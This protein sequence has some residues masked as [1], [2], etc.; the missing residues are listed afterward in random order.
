MNIIKKNSILLK[1]NTLV[2]ELVVVRVNKFDESSA[3]SFAEDVSQAH[4]TGQKVIPVLIDSY[5]GEVYS[6]MSMINTIKSSELPIA[7][8]VD[9]KAMSCGAYLLAFGAKG[10]RFATPGSTIMIHDVSSFAYGKIEEMKAK[11]REGERLNEILTKELSQVCGK[12]DDY[13]SKLIH[14]AGHADVFLNPEE[15]KKHGLIDHIRSPKF[16]V[17]VNV[18]ISFE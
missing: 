13:F 7:T 9:G 14:E 3:K 12:K 10:Y 6:L 11:T 17:N 4:N 8:I 1:D 16:S 15:T 2:K 18:D 5:G